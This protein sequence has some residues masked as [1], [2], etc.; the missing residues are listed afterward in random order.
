VGSAQEGIKK[1]GY[2]KSFEEYSETY[3]DK[4]EKIKELKDQ[5]TALKEASETSAETLGQAG[6]S[7]NS[8]KNP[9]ETTVEA[10]KEGSTTLCANVRTMQ[11]QAAEAAD[12]ALARSY[13]SIKVKLHLSLSKGHLRG[14]STN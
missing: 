10:S 5:L 11:K 6:T 4:R 9:K 12:E 7:R 1:R 14:T 8:N 13:L 2:F 3:T